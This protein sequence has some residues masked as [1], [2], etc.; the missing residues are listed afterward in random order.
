MIA[1]GSLV[2]LLTGTVAVITG[3]AIVVAPSATSRRVF[4]NVE[5]HPDRWR[6]VGLLIAGLGAL[7]VWAPAFG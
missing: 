3:A 1:L 6:G 7:L 2:L 5:T 4:P